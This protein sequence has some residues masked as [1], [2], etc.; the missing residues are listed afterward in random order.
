M[1]VR[2][3]EVMRDDYRGA[4]WHRDVLADV[5]ARL[6]PPS[7][8]PCTF[9]Q[10]AWRRQLVNFV[11]VEDAAPQSL[12]ACRQALAEYVSESR[13]WDGRVNSARPLIVAFSGEAVSAQGLAAEQAFGWRVLQDWHDHDPAGWPEDVA[14][15]PHEPFWSMC[16]DGMQLFV[17]MSC[18]SHSARKSRN[19]GRHLLFIVNPRERFDIVAGD[20]L[21]G[22]KVRSNIRQRCV[23]YDGQDHAPE[24]GSYM[25]GE[26]EW[27][28]YA[29]SDVNGQMADECP[30]RFRG[31][32]RP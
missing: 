32:A 14:T 17:N 29:L 22:R 5:G 15:D 31:Q 23:D 19:L 27:R 3:T 13:R 20:T 26:I 10:N 30:F 6:T 9:S 2:Q 12:G 24:L 28:Q 11:F 18:P 1:L 25:A 7:A 4:A 21:A 8:F 16:F